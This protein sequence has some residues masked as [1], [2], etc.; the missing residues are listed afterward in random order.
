MAE[1]GLPLAGETPSV[2]SARVTASR[3]ERFA[4]C[5]SLPLQPPFTAAVAAALSLATDSSDS[6]AAAVLGMVRD[7]VP[8]SA[9][10]LHARST[11]GLPLS[12]RATTAAAVAAAATTTAA[13]DDS[14]DRE[15]A[16]LL[17][18]HRL[19]QVAM[20]LEDMLAVQGQT[21]LQ[22]RKAVEALCRDVTPA[23]AETA[24]RGI[25]Y[26]SIWARPFALVWAKQG[27][28]QFWPSMALGRGPLVDGGQLTTSCTLFYAHYNI[29][30]FGQASIEA[31]MCRT[32]Y[33]MTLICTCEG[34]DVYCSSLQLYS[35]TL[36][37]Y[38][39]LAS[40]AYQSV[41]LYATLYAPIVTLV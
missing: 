16:L 2:T 18:K 8:L 34:I 28:N 26:S 29:A 5:W 4:L 25:S 38:G 27:K 23:M 41:A 15:A 31:V 11:V 22:W 30:F 40:V 9:A 24:R 6:N 33:T 3:A 7:G 14:T 21:R 36:L 1:T 10:V 20:L 12:D 35:M 37:F 19:P 39:T 32:A 17:L 13:A